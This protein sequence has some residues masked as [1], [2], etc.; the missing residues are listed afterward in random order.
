MGS[1]LVRS[2]GVTAVIDDE[3]AHAGSKGRPRAPKVSV[4]ERTVATLPEVFKHTLVRAPPANTRERHGHDVT[5]RCDARDRVQPREHGPATRS[6]ADQQVRFVPVAAKQ[7]G[8]RGRVT[9]RT[10]EIGPARLRD[11]EPDRYRIA[12]RHFLPCA[13]YRSTVQPVARRGM[14]RNCLFF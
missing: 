3:D 14:G 6:R 1:F 9:F 12:A 5:R 7:L 11:V 8:V 2:E 13:G 10:V 4:C